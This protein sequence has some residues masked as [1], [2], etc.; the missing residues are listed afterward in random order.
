MSFTLGFNY[1]PHYSA[2]NGY[3][4]AKHILEQCVF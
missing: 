1:E 3:S 2:D 4:L